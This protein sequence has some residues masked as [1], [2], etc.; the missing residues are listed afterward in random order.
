MSKVH[1]RRLNRQAALAAGLVTLLVGATLA[2]APAAVAANQNEVVMRLN[3]DGTASVAADAAFPDATP[4]T[5]T[6][7]D[8]GAHTP[9]L[10]HSLQNRVVRT[11]D[12][13]GY[14]IDYDVN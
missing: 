4:T 7:A 14:V 10:D 9:G 11:Y 13:Y 1:V 6:S 5:Y 8:T 3:Y 12:Q 2:S